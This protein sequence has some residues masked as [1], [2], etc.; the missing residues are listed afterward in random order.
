MCEMNINWPVRNIFGHQLGAKINTLTNSYSCVLHV[1]L[2]I[3]QISTLILLICSS[4]TQHSSCTF[5]LNA[6]FIHF[7]DEKLIGQVHFVIELIDG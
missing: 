5:S 2:L 6:F 3:V 1:E 4:C 7:C